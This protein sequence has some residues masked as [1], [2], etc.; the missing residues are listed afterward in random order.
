[1]HDHVNVCVYINVYYAFVKSVLSKH[2]YY[3][4]EVS[5]AL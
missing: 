3:Y 1:M 4:F 2:Y 5:V